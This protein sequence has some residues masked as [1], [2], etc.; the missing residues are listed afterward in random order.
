DQRKAVPPK[1]VAIATVLR[2]RTT[3][4]WRDASGE[5]LLQIADPHPNLAAGQT[6]R[7]TGMLQRPA[8]AQNP[9]QFDW[10][11]YYR[12]R[13]VIASFTV[14]HAASIAVIDDPGPGPLTAARI[15]VRRLL[16]DGFPA[17]R[18][19]DH[20]LLQALLLGD[21]DPQLRDVQDQFIRTGTAHHL[22]ISGTHVALL[23]TIVWGVCRLLTLRPRVSAVV[24]L[25]FTV[26]YGSLALPSPPVVRSVVLAAAF[27]IG[28]IGGRRGEALQLLCVSVVAML[29]YHPPDLLNAGFQ[30]S[31]GT[32]LGMIL[33]TGPT[34][35]AIAR[36]RGWDDPDLIVARSFENPSALTRAVRRIDR[37]LMATLATGLVAWLVSMP[38][39]AYHFE[40]LNPW[41]IVAGIVLAPVV[42]LALV[43]GFLKVT[44]TLLWPAMAPQWAWLVVWP[45]AGMRHVVDWLAGWPLADV[46]V[47]PSPWWLIGAFYGLMLLGLVRRTPQGARWVVRAARVVAL[48]FIV[49][50][51]LQA[52]VS[53]PTPAGTT[54]VTVLSVGAGQCAVVQPPGGRTVLLDAGSSTLADP[55]GKCLGPFLRHAR[56]ASV[57]TLVL[58]HADYDHVSAAAQVVRAYGVREVLTGGQFIEHGGNDQ[59]RALLAELRAAHRPPRVVYPGQPIPIGAVTTLEVLW[60]PQAGLPDKLSPNDGSLVLM[61]TH[62]GK[63]ILFPG[64]IQDGAMHE[65]LKN[66]AR[67]RA[68]VL[69]A[70]HHGSAES[71][72]AQFVDA[73]DPKFIVSSN[74]RT[75]T[76]KQRQF[77]RAIGS[78]PLYRTN[79]VGAVT[80]VMDERGNV[81]V[82][83]FVK[84]SK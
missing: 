4:G 21:N 18:S 66:P 10:A 84:G 44:L 72:T 54:R 52:A 64:D 39:I 24:A 30:L 2:V 70:M 9:G 32:V 57:D 58:S 41:A 61:L 73:V 53:P 20:A 28:V 67:I 62:A 74:D 12:E 1:Q 46:P 50:P 35:D 7:A 49:A 27:G 80:I 25:V 3:D 82:E 43:G 79:D 11:Q 40:Q 83:P 19:L 8:P 60:P 59:T 37:A 78:R 26:G 76:A 68:D 16:A 14:G 31:F 6:V 23:G 47:P 77:E 29:V 5:A 15:K 63:R 81:T 45:V 71:L 38:L 22:A 36:G 55:L 13:R 69:V 65:L 56:V 34:M 48:A 33:F 75:L 42:F 17:P 51:P